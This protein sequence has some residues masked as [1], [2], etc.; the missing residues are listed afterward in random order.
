MRD[1]IEA[2]TAD[3]HILSRGVS[4]NYPPED[5]P[6][7]NVAYLGVTK[8]ELARALEEIEALFKNFTADDNKTLPSYN[9]FSPDYRFRNRLPLPKS[10]IE[11]FEDDESIDGCKLRDLIFEYWITSINDS[12]CGQLGFSDVACLHEEDLKPY[13]ILIPIEN[14][15]IQVKNSFFSYT[16]GTVFRATFEEKNVLDMWKFSPL[17]NFQKDTVGTFLNSTYPPS[18]YGTPRVA[19]AVNLVRNLVEATLSF[20]INI[21]SSFVPKQGGEYLLDSYMCRLLFFFYHLLC[22]VR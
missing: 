2:V 15:I 11:G 8:W 21:D 10:Y 13:A 17:L 5:Q 16:D 3:T 19:R 1:E 6:T 22:S 20:D 7:S 4:S 12:R 18:A 14:K 9:F